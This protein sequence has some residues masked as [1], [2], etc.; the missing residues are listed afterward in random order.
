MSL[1]EN[2][3]FKKEEQPRVGLIKFEKGKSNKE[4]VDK[5]CKNENKIIK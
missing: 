1:K 4:R 5:R 3:Y 2:I